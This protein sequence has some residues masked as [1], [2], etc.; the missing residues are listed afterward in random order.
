[1]NGYVGENTTIDFTK[2]FPAAEEQQQTPE[3]V[4]DVGD[5]NSPSITNSK[6]LFNVASPTHSSQVTPDIF[7]FEHKRKYINEK[8][9]QYKKKV[10]RVNTCYGRL[11][12]SCE[13]ILAFTTMVITIVIMFILA[14]LSSGAFAVLSKEEHLIAEDVTIATMK[15]NRL[16]VTLRIAVFN[17][18]TSTSNIFEYNTTRHEFVTLL[19]KLYLTVPDLSKYQNYSKVN[20]VPT[21]RSDV[22]SF[23]NYQSLIINYVL[24][25]EYEMAKQLCSSVEYFRMQEQVRF[26]FS[27]FLRIG[28]SAAYNEDLYVLDATIV[29]LSLIAFTFVVIFPAITIIFGLRI[30][31]DSLFAENLKK[32]DAYKVLETV[33]NNFVQLQFGEF[34]KRK[35]QHVN[36]LFL[37]KIHHYNELCEKTYTIEVNLLDMQ[38]TDNTTLISSRLSDSSLESNQI[39]KQLE[40]DLD[41]LDVQKYEL[42][43]EILTDFFDV[44]G[45]SFLGSSV[46]KRSSDKVKQVI[47]NYSSNLPNDLFS[48]EELSIALKFVNIHKEFQSE[49]RKQKLNKMEKFKQ[50]AVTNNR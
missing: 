43:F 14:I 28:E 26:D 27:I 16:V 50:K 2:Q 45:V 19:P 12:L 47:D 30:R 48:E 34:C 10:F 20:F 35:N 25:K 33:S 3:T 21:V 32:S 15:L 24:S 23:L 39:R 49:Q 17:N 31:N 4:V 22:N 46:C 18:E 37:Q 13:R 6:T 42:A 11:E 40:T 8:N 44:N 9:E 36:F 5:V 38:E 29:N 7:S 41:V 1:M